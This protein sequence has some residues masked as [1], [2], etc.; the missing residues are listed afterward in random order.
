MK[1]RY[2]QTFVD[3]AQLSLSEQRTGWEGKDETGDM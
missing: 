3:K 1:R 2:M